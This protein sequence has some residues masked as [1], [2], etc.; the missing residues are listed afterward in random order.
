MS[1]GSLRWT[2]RLLHQPA[3]GPLEAQVRLKDFR[4]GGAGGAGAVAARDA[5][6]P[7]A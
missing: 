1:M 3:S 5:G 2:D 7:N 6:D 4:H